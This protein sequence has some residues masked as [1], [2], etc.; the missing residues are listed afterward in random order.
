MRDMID[1]E[2]AWELFENTGNIES[3]MLYSEYK[4][5]SA[6]LKTDEY[7]TDDGSCADNL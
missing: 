6:R 7:N 3:Y 4:N 2:F 1:T 5:L